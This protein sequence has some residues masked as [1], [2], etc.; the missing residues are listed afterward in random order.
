ML[1]VS[2]RLASCGRMAREKRGF[3]AS[4]LLLFVFLCAVSA[5]CRGQAQ[6][7]LCDKGLGS[8]SSEFITGV[9][10]TVGASKN[11][12]FASHT[13]DATLQWGKNVL[14]VVQGAWQVDIDVMGA[15]LGLGV[16]VVAFQIKK[17]EIDDLMTYEV[18]SLRKPPQLL[19]TIT[20]GDYYDAQDFNLQ[21]HNEIWTDDAGAVDGFENFPLSSYDF[22][23]TVVLRF[24]K[25]RLID[26]SSQYQPYF[27]RKIAQIRAQ[28]DSKALSEFKKS[29]GKL[30]SHSSLSMGDLHLLLRTKIKVLEIVWSYL[31]SGREQDAWN[32]LADMWPP[33]DLSRI[34][35]AITDARAR[36]ILRQVDGD[37]KPGRSVPGKH[38]AYIFDLTTER[39]TT[40]AA[41]A[42]VQTVGPNRMPMPGGESGQKSYS[43]VDTKPK[44]IYLGIPSTA[45]DNQ[46]VSNS[47][48]FLNLVVDAAGKVQ[49]AQLANKAD[50]GPIGDALIKAS[51]TWNFIPAFKSDRAVACRIQL[52]VYPE[53]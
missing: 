50:S 41:P 24:E 28:L 52:G 43:S 39:E 15:D 29:D 45:D 32:A 21:G 23:P 31:Y 46:A 8:F 6:R 17:S 14:P 38:H 26:V 27:D 47:E 1:L 40:D 10:A 19:R 53:Q 37:S 18:Y 7:I 3:D 12:G 13:C 5:P 4:S 48:V 30:S 11:G 22:V 33:T 51:T 9:T 36:G 49:S 34:R 16:P 2:R 25:R 35:E 42:S 20:G 44:A